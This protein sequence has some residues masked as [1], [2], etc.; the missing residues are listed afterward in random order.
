MECLRTGSSACHVS[1]QLSLRAAKGPQNDVVIKLPHTSFCERKKFCIAGCL[2][3]RK[4]GDPTVMNYK[5]QQST[6]MKYKQQ[7]STVVNY[8]QQESTVMNYKQQESTAMNY[9]QQ[10]STVM[11]YKRLDSALMQYNLNALH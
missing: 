7:E 6:V 5:Q 11:Q 4:N 3:L 1:S 10:E 2:W 8:K 9:N